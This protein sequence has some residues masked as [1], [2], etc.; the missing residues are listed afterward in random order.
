MPSWPDR[1]RLAPPASSDGA[2]SVTFEDRL[3]KLEA[4]KAAQQ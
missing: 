2:V 4:D 3:A 1:A